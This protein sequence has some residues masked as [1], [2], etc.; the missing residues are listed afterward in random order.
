MVITVISGN[1]NKYKDILDMSTE[2]VK[3]DLM[4]EIFT[5]IN[6]ILFSQET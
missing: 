5:M 1:V 2:E 4:N 6:E 3:I